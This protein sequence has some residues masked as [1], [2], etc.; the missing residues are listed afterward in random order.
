MIVRND[1]Q[2]LSILN[3]FRH[4]DLVLFLRDLHGMLDQQGFQIIINLYSNTLKNEN[5]RNCLRNVL[6]VEFKSIAQILRKA[7]N[8][9]CRKFFSL[10]SGCGSAL[11]T[12]CVTQN[13]DYFCGIEKKESLHY[14]A[15]TAANFFEKDYKHFLSN[16]K[17][18]IEFHN[19]SL[20]NFDWS[21]GDL[22]LANSACFDD[23]LM[24]KISA[25]ADGLKVGSTFIT[26]SKRLSSKKI[27]VVYQCCF[28]M[29]WGRA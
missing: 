25:L 22:I 28:N 23:E 13:F 9:N 5:E 3:S 2:V 1:V 20:L 18:V 11:F 29:R 10:G 24:K 7:P 17:R 27:K 14:L 16:D 12:A 15:K 6:E 26:F 19:E 21:D 8:S 4:K